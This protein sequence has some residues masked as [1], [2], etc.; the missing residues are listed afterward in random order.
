LALGIGQ[1]V[2]QRLATRYRAERI[3]EKIE[4]LAFLQAERPDAIENPRGWLRCAI[5]EDYGPP[6]GYKSQAERDAETVAQQRQDEEMQQAEAAA[7][8]SEEEARER[9][10]Q[11]AAAQH[12]HLEKTYGT[13]QCEFDLWR[14]CLDEFKATMPAATFQT[15]VADT[16]LLSLQDG[17]AL[18][19]LPN[20]GVR[21]WVENRLTRNIG[22]ILS[23]YSGVQKVTVKFAV[24]DQSGARASVA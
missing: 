9:Q 3:L 5:E 16:I 8:R 4:F 13:T 18:V 24:L 11:E 6:D 10:Q 21:D 19:G 23:S 1:T 7:L 20:P 12:A 14:Q 22:R 2:A 15:C 17:E